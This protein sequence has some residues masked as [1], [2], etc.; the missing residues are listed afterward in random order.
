VG[1]IATE[2]VLEALEQRGVAR[3]IAKPLDE[4]MKMSADIRRRYG[5]QVA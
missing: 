3:P 4:A 2:K 1:N 5:A